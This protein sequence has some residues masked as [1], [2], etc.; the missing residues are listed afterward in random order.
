M[1]IIF[2]IAQNM[3]E[4]LP[5]TALAAT[6]GPAPPIFAFVAPV[7]VPIADVVTTHVAVAAAVDWPANAAPMAV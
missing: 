2:H 1:A 3:D 4:E 7:V 5:A 6:D